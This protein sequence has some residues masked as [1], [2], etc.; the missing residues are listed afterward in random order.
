MKHKVAN[1]TFESNSAGAY[2]ARDVEKSFGSAAEK[3]G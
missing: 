2:Y 1:V 3:P